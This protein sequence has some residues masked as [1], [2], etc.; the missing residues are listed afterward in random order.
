M[1][2][3]LHVSVQGQNRHVESVGLRCELEE[4]VHFYGPHSERVGGEGFRRR[5]YDVVSKRDPH[6]AGLG[7]G[8][9]VTSRH[10]VTT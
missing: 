5:V 4:R 7:S 9:T 1:G 3:V 10:D 8:H 2:H 6:V